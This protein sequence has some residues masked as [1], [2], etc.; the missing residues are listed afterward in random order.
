MYFMTNL[1][2]ES[3][4]TIMYHEI[5]L[6]SHQ[7][8]CLNCPRKKSGSRIAMTEICA[9]VWLNVLF[10]SLSASLSSAELFVKV[11]GTSCYETRDRLSRK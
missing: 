5:P 10:D 8:R 4:D 3:I 11:I 1:D 2:S 9:I 6:V 7:P